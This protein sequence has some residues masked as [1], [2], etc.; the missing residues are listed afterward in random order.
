MERERTSISI[1]ASPLA[2]AVM[3]ERDH[4]LTTFRS[5]PL[6]FSAM[7]ASPAHTKVPVARAITRVC[8]RLR[9]SASL[10]ASAAQDERVEAALGDERCVRAKATKLFRL[11]TSLGTHPHPRV[12]HGGGV[13]SDCVVRGTPPPPC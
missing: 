6:P 4:S 10:A 3:L 1:A 5:R 13:I 8:R 11:V 12:K 9:P 2:M 7:H